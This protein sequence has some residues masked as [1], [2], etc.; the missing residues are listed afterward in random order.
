MKKCM[1]LLGVAVAALASC[2]NEEVVSVPENAAIKFA[3]AFVDKAT[4]ADVTTASIT[5]FW[6][7]GDY[8]NSGSWVDVF[9]NVKVTGNNNT[10]QSAWTPEDVAY[11]Q[12]TKSYNFGAYADG[13][14]SNSNVE[15]AP[16]TNTLTFTDYTAAD[17]DLIA[18]TA[19]NKS[20][21]GTNE[22]DLVD[23]SFKH[24]LAKVKFTFK[25]NAADTYTMAVTNLKIN[26]AI[27]TA[28]GT[29]TTSDVINWNGTATGSGVEAY[30]YEPITD[31]A[32]ATQQASSEV[33]YVIPQENTNNATVSFTVSYTDGSG[34]EPKTK[35]VTGVALSIDT[36]N[37]WVAGYS[38]NYVTTI[39]PDDIDDTLKPILFDVIEVDPFEKDQDV[40]FDI[41]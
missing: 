21:D 18:A 2:T 7:F 38:Y 36:E 37:E 1:F 32:T 14:T 17:N 41:Q 16:A 25:T 12:A 26:N 4:K 9:N 20:W 6:V 22:P 30:G 15:Y 8:D 11:W 35:D 5:N 33:Q 23:L 40:N 24:M 10:D 13:T 27:K 3:G 28:T 29:F 31:F 34:A 39:D 19:T